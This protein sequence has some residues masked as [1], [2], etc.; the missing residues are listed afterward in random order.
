MSMR[1]LKELKENIRSDGGCKCERDGRANRMEEYMAFG[2]IAESENASE[3]KSGE[4][5]TSVE[6]DTRVHWARACTTIG[7]VGILI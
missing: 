5:K 7:M 6:P 4:E 1:L 2:N 3:E